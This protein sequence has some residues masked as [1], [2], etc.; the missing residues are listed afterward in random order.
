MRQRTWAC[1]DLGY[2]VT[3]RALDK[4]RGLLLQVARD[5]NA[6]AL[7]LYQQRIRDLGEQPRSLRDFAD[8]CDNLNAVRAE[9]RLGLLSLRTVF[10]MLRPLVEG[11][12]RC[13]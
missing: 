13:A 1:S 12:A 5:N 8:Y 10:R 2:S 11:G 3:Q 4:C 6:E 9:A 7:A